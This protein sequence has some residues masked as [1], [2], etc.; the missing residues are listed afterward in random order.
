MRSGPRTPITTPSV[1]VSPERALRLR[2]KPEAPTTGYVDG[3]WWPRSRDLAVELPIL[4]AGLAVRLGQIRRVSYNLAEWNAVGRR[5]DAGGGMVRLGGFHFQGSDT[6][7]VIDADQRRIT[8]LVVPPATAP[9]SA[10]A[11][12]MAAASRDNTERASELLAG[13]G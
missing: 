12:S 3:A 8:L 13:I 7:D 9:A 4:L 5:L 11:V 1:G 2:L 10:H 6:V